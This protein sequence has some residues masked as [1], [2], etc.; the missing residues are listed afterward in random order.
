MAGEISK[1]R[2][3]PIVNSATQ[4]NKLHDKQVSRLMRKQHQME[5]HIADESQ[6]RVQ[7]ENYFTEIAAKQFFNQS[8]KSS[9]TQST[10]EAIPPSLLELYETGLSD[11]VLA[12]D[13]AEISYL[14]AEEIETLI[15]F[16][17]VDGKKK[18]KFAELSEKLE[19]AR[20]GQ[21][22]GLIDEAART[23]CN[24]NKSEI[25]L[26]LCYLFEDLI[27][28][29]S[30]ESLRDRLKKIIKALERQESAYLFNYFSS[31][32]ILKASPNTSVN[33]GALDKMANISSGYVKLS[34]LRQTLQFVSQ[35]LP[36][37]E[38]HK[39][40]S[41]FMKF[42]ARN[43]KKIAT[44][45]ENR[46]SK[47]ELANIL[48]QER[49]LIILNSIY[50]QCRRICFKMKKFTEVEEKYGDFMLQIITVIES[51][52]VSLEGLQNMERMLGIKNLTL[53]VNR[54]FVKNFHAMLAKLPQ[55]IFY[56]EVLRDKLLD[57]M[58]NFTQQIEGLME[59]KNNGLSFLR[60]KPFR[61]SKI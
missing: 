21:E 61:K 46:E 32:N 28:K 7:D 35:T 2:P 26:M 1:I 4:D 25:Y 37:K 40:V 23:V 27:R 34:S 19:G 18:A 44:L 57:S 52:M 39:M 14:V 10:R 31:Q 51:S 33:A 22:E 50:N 8:E 47:E 55:P 11:S 42:Q 53:E 30:R 5:A 6:G 58:R 54:A 48:Q 49:N 41:I 38:M 16:I 17:D 24:G 3:S 13:G 36:D 43:L 45:A 56:S 12:T 29:K 20:E 60:R 9:S 59:P 15:E